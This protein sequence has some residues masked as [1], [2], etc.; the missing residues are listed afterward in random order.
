MSSSLPSGSALFSAPSGARGRQR[1][2]GVPKKAD[3]ATCDVW[4][5]EGPGDADPR[6]RVNHLGLDRADIHFSA[7]EACR[8]MGR[9][10]VRDVF[11]HCCGGVSFL[12]LGPVFERGCGRYLATIPATLLRIGCCHLSDATPCGGVV[13]VYWGY[14][15]R[16]PNISGS[17]TIYLTPV[18]IP[19]T[20]QEP[21]WSPAHITRVA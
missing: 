3:H 1:A 11:S 12:H 15:G 18:R 8:R 19:G 4:S 9:P 5:E 16:S 13:F 6:A 14:R 2:R 17:T 21:G 20:A 7:E 10:R